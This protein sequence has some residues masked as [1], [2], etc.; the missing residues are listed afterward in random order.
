MNKQDYSIA[1]RIYFFTYK[2]LSRLI[3][4]LKACFAGFWLGIF[5]RKTLYFIDNFYYDI[6]N[7]A[8]YSED[9]NRDGLWSWEEKVI[10]KYFKDCKRLL[11]AAAG[12]GREVLA[13]RRLGHDVDGFECH[14]RLVN[15]ANGLLKKEGLTPN[16]QLAPRDHCPDSSKMYDGIVVGWGAYMLIQGR[17]Q[18]I[19]FL[20]KLRS[21]TVEQSPILLSFFYHSFYGFTA[22][23]LKLIARIGNVL[24]KVFRGAR[25]E[26]G[27]DLAPT[28]VRY[29]TR[30]EIAAELHETGFELAFYST[31]CY[32]HAVGIASKQGDAGNTA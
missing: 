5:N 15:F 11:V 19:A 17:E 21:Q 8:Y 10:N 18:R 4:L 6:Y 1:I 27:A 16:I 12:G 24:K 22:Y 32:G 23:R 14:S 28:Y 2:I 9:Y 29:F 31:D 25:L 20:K 13:L 3:E 26:P 7:K 30:E